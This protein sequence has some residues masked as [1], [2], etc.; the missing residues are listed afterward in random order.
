LVGKP[1]GKSPLG[2]ARQRLVDNVRVYLGE[3][4][5]EVVDWMQDR[6]QLR[7]LENMVMKFS[8]P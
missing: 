8:I 4:G 5:W 7:I 2:R 6:D 1:E 3:M